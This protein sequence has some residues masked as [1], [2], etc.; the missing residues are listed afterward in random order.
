MSIHLITFDLDDTFWHAAPAIDHAE[1]CLREWLSINT[2]QLGLF[3]LERLAQ[4]R[5]QV[6]T[7]DPELRHRVSTLRRL[8]LQ[9]ALEE[10]GYSQSE[11]QE[12]AE[13]G[14]QVFL[15]ARHTVQIFPEV[16]PLLEQLQGH[17][18]LGVLTN[19]NANIHRLGLGHYFQFALSAEE[20]G[21]GKPDQRPFHEALRRAGVAAEHSVHIGD[22]PLDDI[23]GAKQ[24]GIRAVWFNPSAA[25]WSQAGHEPDAEIRNL[26]EVPALLKQWT[27]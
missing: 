15:A 3:T 14:F 8:V 2:P 12:A 7:G 24:M 25:T 6:I 26:A 5:Q 20:L 11:A 16:R 27:R 1:H 19:G 13:Q 9:T 17:Y 22:H 10:A 23:Q 4:T 18:Q 21:V